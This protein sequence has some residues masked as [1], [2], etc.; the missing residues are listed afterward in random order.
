[1]KLVRNRPPGVRFKPGSL[2][3]IYDELRRRVAVLESRAT[4]ADGAEGVARQR[5]NEKTLAEAQVR[6]QLAVEIGR[7]G[8][9]EWEPGTN[10]TYFSP[11]W[12]QQLGFIGDE[13]MQYEDWK[14]WLHP[15]DRERVLEVL[16][17]YVAQ[18]E[19]EYLVEY[20]MRHRTGGYRWFMSRGMALW[21]PA[22]PM[23]LIGIRLDVTESKESEQRIRE[24]GQH[25]PLTGL[26][27]R[28][29]LSD[30][31]ERILASAHRSSTGVAIVFIDLDRFK[32]IND[33]HG[34]EAGDAVLRAVAERLLASVRKGDIPGRLGGDEFLVILSDV[35]S[36]GSAASVA[37]HLL[38][39]LNRPYPVGSLELALSPSIGIALFPLD[40]DNLDA[41]IRHADHAMYAAKEGGGSRVRF[42]TQELAPEADMA[43]EEQLR[44]ALERG[45]FEVYLQPITSLRT[46]E[47]RGAEAL[48][49]WHRQGNELV[50]PDEFI[51]IAKASGLIGELGE[52]AFRSGCRLLLQLLQEQLPQMELAINFSPV[53]FRQNNF[54]RRL[55]TLVDE[56]GIDPNFI[57]IELRESAVMQNFDAALRTLNEVRSLGV[58]VV[59]DHFG[60]GA[61]GIGALSRLPV[62]TLK[63]DQV[64]V[65]TLGQGRNSE[66]VIDAAIAI[67]RTLGVNIVA[68]GIESAAAID[69]LR[70]HDC[71]FGQGFALG[72]PMAAGEF[73]RWYRAHLH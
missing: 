46:A 72:A 28:A 27:N 47:V 4:P 70:D 43:L 3:G 16:R 48:L 8:F 52:W 49:R 19:G 35:S 2:S 33:T 9:W 58:H 32:E 26:P 1:M 18:P 51:P 21:A 42:F 68:E 6:L 54:P 15:D 37:D 17:A 13:A 25:D 71:Q 30:Y 23:R 24:A 31:A 55:A 29:L 12:K 53:E 14:S 38:A 66:A 10:E 45:E 7:L 62:E 64:F 59:L 61:C 73:R 36:A 11:E 65:R 40:G 56:S 50:L 39:N 63:V 69:F 5:L 67:G 60:E 34:H 41:L 57:Q 44:S 20:R 22:T